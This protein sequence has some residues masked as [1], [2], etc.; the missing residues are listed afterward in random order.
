MVKSVFLVFFS[1]A[2]TNH[3]LGQFSFKD[4]G[5]NARIQ[6]GAMEAI[7]KKFHLQK[8]NEF[9][10]RLFIFPKWT[11]DNE[12]LSIFILTFKTGEWKARL[13]RNAWSTGKSQEIQLKPDRLDSLWKELDKN[14]V[15]NIPL[16]QELVDKNGETLID[17]LQGDD[18]SVFYSFELLNKNAVRHYAYK[19]PTEFSRRYDDIPTLKSVSIIV[20]LIL[21]ICQLEKMNC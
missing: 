3:S 6:S 14:N 15:L 4:D 2:V 8:D 16:A 7:D 18:N 5:T 9:E 12:G 11:D 13:F 1:L 20:Q 10:L 19:C 21:N 17:Q